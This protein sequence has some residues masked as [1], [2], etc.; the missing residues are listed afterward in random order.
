M[1]EMKE[2]E[3]KPGR[4]FFFGQ[5]VCSAHSDK[6]VQMKTFDERVSGSVS[7]WIID[8]TL[9]SCRRFIASV[10]I[11]KF[12]LVLQSHADSFGFHLCLSVTL[13]FICKMGKRQVVKNKV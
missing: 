10:F 3:T 4:I 13:I 2:Y 8:N 12:C 7:G 11:F 5:M 9:S 6:D 1:A